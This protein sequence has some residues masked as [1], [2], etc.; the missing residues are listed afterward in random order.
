MPLERGERI[1]VELFAPAEAAINIDRIE[2]ADVFTSSESEDVP[3]DDMGVPVNTALEAAR[4]YWG[5][6]W[7][8]GHLGNR[9]DGSPIAAGKVAPVA[10]FAAIGDEGAAA[11][12]RLRTRMVANSGRPMTF[13]YTT[14]NVA[15]NAWGYAFGPVHQHT[16]SVGDATQSDVLA[17]SRETDGSLANITGL[18]ADL[19]LGPQ[20]NLTALYE[21]SNLYAFFVAVTGDIDHSLSTLQT[22]AALTPVAGIEGLGIGTALQR[23]FN[24][25]REIADPIYHPINPANWLNDTV[26]EIRRIVGSDTAATIS[27]LGGFGGALAGGTDSLLGIRLDPPGVN[28]AYQPFYGTMSGRS[29]ADGVE[30]PTYTGSSRG[31]SIETVIDVTGREPTAVASIQVDGIGLVGPIRDRRQTSDLRAGHSVLIGRITLPT[32]AELD[33]ARAVYR[34]DGRLWL[35]ER[36]S[37]DTPPSP[38]WGV[39]LASIGG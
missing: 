23:H 34:I 25:L 18:H 21:V 24:V 3:V 35:L 33:L 6:R 10:S 29:D 30:Q 12:E 37:K 19:E 5:F 17:L 7:A 39:R 38:T 31:T 28:D 27:Q 8:L 15:T 22:D 20:V 9:Q 13:P 2:L 16:I 26:T 4:I 14:G 36:G 32:T 11:L 1:P